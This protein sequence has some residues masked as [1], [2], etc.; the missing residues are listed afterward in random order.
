MQCPSCGGTDIEVNQALGDTICVNC[1]VVLEESCIVNQ[2]N[3]EES[4]G[5]SSAIGQFVS[6]TCTQPYNRTA[7]WP[8]LNSQ[9][10]REITLANN[11]RKIEQVAAMLHL[12]EH[13][14][15]AA[16][17]F[18]RLAL[19]RNFVAGRR[20]THVTC[21]CLYTVCRKEQSPHMLIDFSDVVQVNVYRLGAT[22]LRFRRLLNLEL[23]M[24]DPGLFI[25]RY[26]AR[27]E[28]G[29]QTNA[30]AR[31]ALR[32]VARMKRDWL[33][34]GRRPSG[35][36]A[37]ALLI[38]ARMHGI[39]LIKED[40]S[41][42]MHVC[43]ATVTNRLREFEMTPA[44]FLSVDQFMSSDNEKGCPLSEIEFD[45][46]CF[47]RNQIREGKVTSA[48]D[49]QKGAIV[50]SQLANSASPSELKAAL[51]DSFKVCMLDNI[52]LVEAPSAWPKG[53]RKQGGRRKT[54]KSKREVATDQAW[55]DLYGQLEEELEKSEKQESKK[56]VTF[57]G[58]SLP[59]KK[60]EEAS[61]DHVNIKEPPDPDD[62]LAVGID[63]VK[64]KQSKVK[65][66]EDEQTKEKKADE[67]DE[68]KASIVEESFSDVDDDGIENMLL[69][70]EEQRKKEMVWMEM[71]RDYL[72]EQEEKKKRALL[73]DG[74]GSKRRRNKKGGMNAPKGS[75]A[76]AFDFA[77]QQKKISRKIDYS[78]LDGFFDESG[79]F[80]SQEAGADS[81]PN[82]QL[83][84]P[85]APSPE[86]EADDDVL[87]EVVEEHEEAKVKN[88]DMQETTQKD[89]TKDSSTEKVDKLDAEEDDEEED[90]YHEGNDEYYY[91]DDEY[92]GE[93]Y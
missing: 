29:D 78:A 30:V 84:E 23:P 6:E 52:D 48:L 89:A 90:D 2:V 12:G 38:A 91:D 70:P 27:L 92:G 72:L 33:T 65:K 20:S 87:E 69:S 63:A 83:L 93:E 77:M 7:G 45:P 35:I 68:D 28:L 47:I 57:N 16:H 43:G 58:P 76:E 81:L 22:F 25:H 88:E 49:M 15:D 39:P 3:F 55:Q 73:E 86:K 32:V 18:Y 24:V 13:F 42:V 11:R 62:L 85:A 14:V 40:V 26:A 80:S 56:K 74:S 61:K 4:G 82:D 66:E 79:K 60:Q 19:E 1:G 44:A 17:R 31:T 71:H 41:R 37:A 50:E 46:P 75:A 8:G 64:G 10:S 9:P 34:V 67:D 51:M 36:C 59:V 5:A 21:A 53:H 54:M